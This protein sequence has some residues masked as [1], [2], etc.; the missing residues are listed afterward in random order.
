MLDKIVYFLHVVRTGSFSLAAKQY[1]ISASAG[2]RWIIE[3]EE[4]MGISLLKRSTRKVVPTQAGLRLFERFNQVNSE[5]DD[6]FTEIQNLGNDDRGI[7]RIASTPLFARDF[8][9]QIV[10]EYLQQYPHVTFRIL[11]TAFDMDHLDEI[12]FAI[13]ASAVYQGFQEKDSLLVK[14][15][16]LKYPLMACCSPEYINKYGQPEYPEDL[17]RHNCLYASTLVGGNKWVFERD[18][19]MTTV[20]ISQTVEVEDSQFI[21][22]VALNGGGI[23]Y[24]PV[25]LIQDE[26]DD[27]QLVQVLQQYTNSEFEF[28]LYYRP[29]RQ[30]PMRCVNFKDY[31]I[32]RV[33]EISGQE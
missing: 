33:R 1:G 17:R 18:G 19:E 13:R 23:S 9:G 15:S 12:D 30:M 6:I 2:S 5:I 3:L 29:R 7:I 28:S 11:E 16:L 27:G 4:S 25:R 26:L 32:R 14:R 8:L 22:T 20:N 21:K 31:L 24:L 10:G